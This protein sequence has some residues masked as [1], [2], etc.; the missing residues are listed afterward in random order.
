MN[1]TLQRLLADGPLLA[2]L[3]AHRARRL[4]TEP[5]SRR[6]GH[7][8]IVASLDRPLQLD[9]F[10][11]SVA[12]Q[13]RNPPPIAVLHRA[14]DARFAAAY[15]AVLRRHAGLRLESLPET[16]FRADLLAWL[17]R[18]GAGRVCVFVDDLLFRAPFDPAELDAVD[19]LRTLFSL[20][21][22][23]NITW[24]QPLQVAEPVPAF[25]PAPRPD[26]RAWRWSDGVY[27]WRFATAL[28]GAV[29]D[30][31]ELLLAARN[32]HF[33]APNSL[34]T[35]LLRIVRHFR[36]GGLCFAHPRLVNLPLNRVQSDG[37]DFRNL[38]ISPRALLEAWESGL[39][40]DLSGID[41][42]PV[43]SCFAEHAPRLVPRRP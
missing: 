7:A 16:S 28:D 31:R 37:G 10:L 17:A 30:R 34:E 9:A 19:P 39:E 1:A 43:S 8:W 20:R 27:D 29:F 12:A 5:A 32:V 11:R 42:L 2:R 33:R 14:S 15:S 6:A 22:G 26:W 18:P 24:C 21:L 36:R 25:R 4:A 41:A 13:V 3:A 38:G 40:M 23:E 35:G